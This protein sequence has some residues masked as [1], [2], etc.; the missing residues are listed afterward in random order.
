MIF[1]DNEKSGRTIGDQGGHLKTFG[2]LIVSNIQV[3]TSAFEN[4]PP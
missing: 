1:E 4:M 2:S 3:I